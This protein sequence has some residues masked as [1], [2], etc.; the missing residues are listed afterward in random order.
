ML[1]GFK[2]QINL[3]VFLYFRKILFFLLKRCTRKKRCETGSAH[4]QKRDFRSSEFFITVKY[5][6]KVGHRG[7]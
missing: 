6:K 5:H 4:A 2:R 3:E 7:W 1:K